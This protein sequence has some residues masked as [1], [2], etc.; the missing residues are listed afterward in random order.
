[1]TTDFPRI[2]LSLRKEHKLTQ[3]QAAKDLGVSP[4]LLSHYEKGVRECGLQFVVRAAD[5]YHVSCDFLLGR[6]ADRS[7]MAPELVS[8]KARRTENQKPLELSTPED[9][10]QKQVL[11][12][13]HILFRML[14]SCRNTRLT[15]EVTGALSV[16]LYSLFREL[17]G[18]GK[19][20]SRA[21]FSLPDTQFPP[22]AAA[23]VSRSV[24]RVGCLAQ[25]VA[26][27]ASE[28]LSPDAVPSLSEERLR[29]DFPFFASSLIRLLSQAE[30]I[31]RGTI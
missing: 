17:C 22:L 14:Q 16:V 9:R 31:L 24:A 8:P 29:R 30:E 2:L 27:Q 13:V 7:G 20:T 3:K 18:G 23:S 10:Q 1:M 25:G 15:E 26:V 12:A 6:T 4:A 21:L 28:G 11:Q 19:K 5:Y